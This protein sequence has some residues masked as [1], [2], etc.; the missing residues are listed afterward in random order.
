V[1]SN[2]GNFAVSFR[3]KITKTLIIMLTATNIITIGMSVLKV[4]EKHIHKVVES[5]GEKSANSTLLA[6]VYLGRIQRRVQ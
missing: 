3:A 4:P 1:N 5:P 2:A 6:R